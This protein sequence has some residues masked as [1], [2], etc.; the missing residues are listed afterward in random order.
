MTVIPEVFSWDWWAVIV[1]GIGTLAVFSFLYR[2]NK[3]YRF[4]EHFYIGIAT[5]YGV[6]FVCRDPIWPEVVRPLLGLDLSPFPDGTTLKPF[7]YNVFLLL[8]PVIFGS[9]YYCILSRRWNWVAQLVIGLSFGVSAGNQFKGLFIE[10]LPQLFDS[11]KPLYVKDDWLQTF[12]N[13]V[14]TTTLLSAMAYFFFSFKRRP[15][16][17]IEKTSAVGRWMLMGCFG[18]FFGSTIMARMALLVERL[19]MLIRDWWPA[20]SAAFTG[21]PPIT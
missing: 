17:A 10:L 7:S 19:D 2:E 21:T 18:A 4:F 14:F 8:F 15:G 11:F 16:G 12:S 1:G 3:F 13:L 9:L 20:L 5:A 6:V